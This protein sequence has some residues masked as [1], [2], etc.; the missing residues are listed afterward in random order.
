MPERNGGAPKPAKRSIPFSGFAHYNFSG[1]AFY[2]TNIIF[3]V[4]E[5]SCDLIKFNELKTN[6]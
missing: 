4:D 6:Y 2:T 1:F 3:I 5:T